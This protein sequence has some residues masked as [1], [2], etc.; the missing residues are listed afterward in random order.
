MALRAAA[1]GRTCAAL[2]AVYAGGCGA[3]LQDSL[4]KGE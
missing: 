4:I 3:D 2:P 1:H